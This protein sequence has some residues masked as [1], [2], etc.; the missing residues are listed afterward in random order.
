MLRGFTRRFMGIAAL[1]ALAFCALTL[2]FAQT[3]GGAAPPG[4]IILSEKTL[5][6]ISAVATIILIAGG[7]WSLVAT[8]KVQAKALDDHCGNP[9]AHRSLESLQAQFVPTA[10]CAAHHDALTMRLDLLQKSVDRLVP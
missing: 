10:L 3:V 4:Q 7:W 2:A 1:S 6:P 5:I 9:G 8:V